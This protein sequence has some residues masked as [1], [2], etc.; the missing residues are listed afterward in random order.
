MDEIRIAAM[1]I[2]AIIKFK[3]LIV[4]ELTLDEN[5]IKFVTI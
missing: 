5:E 4:F 1:M 2:N 3:T